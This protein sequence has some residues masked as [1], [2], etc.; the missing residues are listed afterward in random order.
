M[1]LGL[2]VVLVY[3]LFLGQAVNS[4]HCL[5]RTRIKIDNFRSSAFRLGVI[6]IDEE[7]KY[8]N[9]IKDKLLKLCLEK[10]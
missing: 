3:E 8:I 2:L 7:E 9:G 1:L 10:I 4:L 6:H 5:R